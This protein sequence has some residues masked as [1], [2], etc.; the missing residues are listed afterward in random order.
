MP[1]FNAMWHWAKLEVPQSEARRRKLHGRISKQF[2]VGQV[3]DHAL[4][5]VQVRQKGAC[6]RMGTLSCA[7]KV[8]G[9][10]LA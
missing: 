1:R 9:F 5:V 6:V 8:G 4:P 2:P 10:M 3:S 7:H